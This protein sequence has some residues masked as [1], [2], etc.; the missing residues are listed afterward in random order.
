MD[1][2]FFRR[3]GGLVSR[4]LIT[5]TLLSVAILVSTVWAMQETGPRAVVT[6]EYLPV[7]STPTLVTAT[8]AQLS[9]GQKV[10]LTGF[11][12]SDNQWVQVKLPGVA[13]GWVPVEGIRVRFDIADLAVPASLERGSEGGVAIV[14][15]EYALVREDS[16][17]T[18]PVVTQL[19]RGD[20]VELTGFRTA[21]GEWIQV[22]LSGRQTGWVDAESITSDYPQSALLPVAGTPPFAGPASLR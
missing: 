19:T 18:Q 20:Q 4:V 5:A 1:R 10:D 8:I 12:T 2:S 17:P 13:G 3:T 21:D 7:R 15:A 22:M 16:G 9:G 6:A 11:R 14:A